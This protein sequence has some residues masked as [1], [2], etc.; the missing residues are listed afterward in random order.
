MSIHF[1]KSLAI[2]SREVRRVLRTRRMVSSVSDRK[3]IP[4]FMD[5][6]LQVPEADWLCL[7]KSAKFDI[8]TLSGRTMPVGKSVKQGNVFSK[9][10]LGLH[11]LR[12]K[13]ST[14]RVFESYSE[15]NAALLELESWRTR[16]GGLDRCGMLAAVRVRRRAHLRWPVARPL[17]R[18]LKRPFRP[19]SLDFR[20]FGQ[21][22]SA[23]GPSL[24]RL[25]AKA[26]RPRASG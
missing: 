9:T 16:R 11:R 4:I 2:L 8:E 5:S 22:H 25:F 12:G 24:F 6:R 15:Y 23:G 1:L 21:G 20:R 13:E 18:P 10:L 3:A 17:N 26:P 7:E 19:I 14:V